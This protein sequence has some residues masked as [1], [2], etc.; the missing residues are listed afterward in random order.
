[1]ATISIV[2]SRLRSAILTYPDGPATST[3]SSC[4]RR[5]NSRTSPWPRRDLCVRSVHEHDIDG[6]CR[7]GAQG[8]PSRAEERPPIPFAALHVVCWI[9]S[10]EEPDRPS[11]AVAVAWDHHLHVSNVKQW[12]LANLNRLH[13]FVPA[14]SP[15]VLSTLEM[16]VRARIGSVFEGSA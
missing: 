3:T 6:W 7:D 4:P 13:I 8:R 14:E 1:M 9:D 5:T 16:C 2:I 11:G 15:D 12:M 10:C